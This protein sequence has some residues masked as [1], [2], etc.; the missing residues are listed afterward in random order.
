M[1]GGR[2]YT[3]STKRIRVRAKVVRLG[4]YITSTLRSADRFL[5][6]GYRTVRAERDEE[7]EK[8]TRDPII[9]V[10]AFHEWMALYVILV[11]V[12]V[13]H[14]VTALRQVTYIA[15]SISLHVDSYLDLAP[16]AR[17]SRPHLSLTGVPQRAGRASETSEERLSLPDYSY[18]PAFTRW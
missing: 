11:E 13:Q 10:C 1:A 16:P 2:C 12:W 3:S 4:R 14:G 9:I 5:I 8:L 15:T 18:N 6:I 7:R 17:S